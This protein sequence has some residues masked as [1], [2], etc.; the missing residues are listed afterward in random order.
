[1]VMRAIDNCFNTNKRG[2]IVLAFVDRAVKMAL[3]SAK[4][5]LKMAGPWVWKH[6]GPLTETPQR[7][8]TLIYGAK[9]AVSAAISTLLDQEA[10]VTN[11]L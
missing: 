10:L 8:C 1:M 6:F 7:G 4:I 3:N 5:L 2:K 9:T 11:F